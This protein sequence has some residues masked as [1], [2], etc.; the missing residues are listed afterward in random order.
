MA[1]RLGLLWRSFLLEWHANEAERD[2]RD[3]VGDGIAK[4]RQRTPNPEDDAA[5]RRAEQGNGAF[6]DLVLRDGGGQLF[7][8][9]D[10]RQGSETRQPEEDEARALENAT[11]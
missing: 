9:D 4:E 6:G 11:R 2:H 3:G 8:G 10:A 5:Q 1:R 7:P